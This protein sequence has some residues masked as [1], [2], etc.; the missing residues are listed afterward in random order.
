MPIF[1]ALFNQI[2]WAEEIWANVVLFFFCVYFNTNRLNKTGIN[3]TEKSKKQTTQ[4]PSA[5][6]PSTLNGIDSNRLFVVDDSQ[7]WW[8]WRFC[9]C[10]WSSHFNTNKRTIWGWNWQC[11][12]WILRSML[13]SGWKNLVYFSKSHNIQQIQ[14]ESNAERHLWDDIWSRNLEEFS[15]SSCLFS[16]GSVFSYPTRCNS[17]LNDRDKKSS[18]LRK[19]FNIIFANDCIRTKDTIVKCIS[20]PKTDVFPV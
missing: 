3:S 19:W 1:S 13:S 7:I 16:F 14:I 5:Q 12:Y 6:T 20:I 9:C 8:K 2:D 4:T 18:V 10:C 15:S 11:L 17:T